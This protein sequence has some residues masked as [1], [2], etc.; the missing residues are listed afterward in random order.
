MT[1][2]TDDLVR[3]LLG[4]SLSAETA[5]AAA[6]APDD[7]Y[8]ASATDAERDVERSQDL[9]HL[10]AVAEHVADDANDVCGT[11][12][13][14]Y[15][16]VIEF[17]RHDDPRSALVVARR[18]L[19][20]HPTAMDLLGEALRAAT[21]CGDY[22]TC[23][24][25]V[26]AADGFDQ[27]LWSQRLFQWLIRY[28]CERIG[29]LPGALERALSLAE[30]YE[31]RYP[32]SDQAYNEHARVLIAVGR[33]DEAGRLLHEVIFGTKGPDANDQRKVEAPRCCLT[34]IDEVLSGRGD[35]ESYRE[36]SLVARKGVQFTAQEQPGVNMGYFLYRD[37]EAQDALICA[38]GGG[39]DGFANKERVRDALRTYR[40]AYR[41]LG[42]REYR[43][44]IEK[45]H[46][47]LS[48]QSGVEDEPLEP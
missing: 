10:R 20:L 28:H 4:R 19:R 12:A 38:L 31:R 42:D 7:L 34:Y 30:A 16:L 32:F 11:A 14:Y 9:R 15:N 29:A 23:E 13:S 39:L 3:Q 27:S 44:T 1:E 37:A 8:F 41:L 33:V 40:C 21:D 5:P 22:A 43:H 2:D 26:A 36:I 6:S 18:G 24:E 45:R 46:L 35:P 25:L 47:I 48:M 17:R